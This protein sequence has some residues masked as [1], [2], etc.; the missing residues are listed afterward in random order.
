MIDNKK[1]RETKEAK[2]IRKQG[3]ETF[4]R[5]EGTYLLS[6]I[7]DPL[8]RTGNKTNQSNRKSTTTNSPKSHQM[9]IS[10]EV[11]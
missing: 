9:T 6:H 11:L 10:D 3:D 7:S 1:S 5:E 8:L 2:E 4:N